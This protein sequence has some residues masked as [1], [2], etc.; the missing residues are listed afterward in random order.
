M[1]SWKSF[2]IFNSMPVSIIKNKIIEFVH[3]DGVQEGNFL[4]NSVFLKA[5]I[6]GVRSIQFSIFSKRLSNFLKSSIERLKKKQKI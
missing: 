3:F 1:K 2:D 6:N 5:H 4:T